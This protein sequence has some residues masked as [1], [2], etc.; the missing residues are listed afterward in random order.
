MI[1]SNRDG[2]AFAKGEQQMCAFALSAT[3]LFLSIL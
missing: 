3:V 2:E 1:R